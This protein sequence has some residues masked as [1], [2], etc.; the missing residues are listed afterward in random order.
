MIRTALLS[1]VLLAPLSGCGE[2]ESPHFVP[3]TGGSSSTTS[4]DRQGP[5]KSSREVTPLTKIEM[6]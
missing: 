6:H 3:A 2:P 1:S 4:A 5:V